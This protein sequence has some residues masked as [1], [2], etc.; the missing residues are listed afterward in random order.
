M[1][2]GIGLCLRYIYLDKYS[3]W[4]SVS[5]EAF[6]DEDEIE[7]KNGKKISK[8]SGSLVEWVEEESYFFKLSAWSNKLLEFYKKNP[9][10]ILPASRKNEV[11]KFVEKGLND[12]SI[13][14]TSFT[15]GIPVP[16]N[17]KHVIYVWLDALT[18]YISA[19]NFPNIEDKK[20]K[21]F[22]AC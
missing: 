10:F 7:D 17:E 6:Y 19:L 14:R 12:L 3:G 20:Y 11:V 13:S 22:L 2:Y 18:N 16:K 8:S 15:W 9:N 4:Y 5:D 1:K 21:R